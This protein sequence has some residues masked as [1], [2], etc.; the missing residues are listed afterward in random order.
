[1]GT[2]LTGRWLYTIEMTP[3]ENNSKPFKPHYTYERAQW[4]YLDEASEQWTPIDL[5]DATA[6]E[7]GAFHGLLL[8]GYFELRLKFLANG[9]PTEP[10][11]MATCVVS[12]NYTKK[13]PYAI[14][15]AVP[16]FSEKVVAR[17]QLP[18][19]YRLS[20]SGVSLQSEMRTLGEDFQL[21]VRLEFVV[22]GYVVIH[23]LD[24]IKAAPKPPE[25]QPTEDP[26]EEPKKG[27]A[28]PKAKTEARVAAYL[29]PRQSRYI[30]L[31]QD[32]LDGRPGAF[33]EFKSEFAS[34]AIARAITEDRGKDHP[35]CS[36]QAV[37]KTDAYKAQ[38][39][40]LLDRPP[41]KPINWEALLKD[42]QGEEQHSVIDEIP[43]EDDDL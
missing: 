34:T 2:G 25:P 11:V 41:R 26:K 35:A 4:N 7:S 12:G 3:S 27:Y 24:Y 8:A 28:W 31:V 18:A 1:M 29:A 43:C 33:E 13:L 20:S 40:P 38:I 16:E 37:D 19:E 36:K 39:K 17:P 32:V 42:R 23:D 21:P 15:S 30:K 22:P 9:L 14:R 10:Q 5:S 6:A